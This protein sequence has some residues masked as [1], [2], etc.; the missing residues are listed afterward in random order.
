MQITEKTKRDI[1]SRSV[2][3]SDFLRMEY[4]E[5]VIKKTNDI[6]ALR[7]C[8]SELSRLYAERK[9]YPESL[10][11]IAKHKE[12]CILQREKNE[13]IKR[14]INLLILGGFYDRLD[15]S[16]K[17]AMKELGQSELFEVKR[18]IIEQLKHEALRFEKI[19][20]I[21][22]ALK[23]YEKL[24]HFVVDQEKTDIKKKMIFCYKKLGK[25]RESIELERQLIRETPNQRVEII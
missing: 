20:R 4:L 12:I 13:C 18:K 7:Y 23:V 24:L 9:M 14:E 6:E 15:I 17:E 8:Y 25:I 5:N 3:M 10:K 1:E 2:T 19:G 16:Y 21:S 11:Y 22:G